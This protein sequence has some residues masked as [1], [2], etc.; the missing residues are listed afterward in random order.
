L[1]R[2]QQGEYP[3]LE[4]SR[5]LEVTLARIQR[6][7][8]D[9]AIAE[10]CVSPFAA[11]PLDKLKEADTLRD[12]FLASLDRLRANAV[13]DPARA[14][15]LRAAF[16]TSY[17]ASRGTTEQMRRSG[18]LKTSDLQAVADRHREMQRLLE[19]HTAESRAAVAGAFALSAR[20]QSASLRTS[21][22]V[23]LL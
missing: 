6:T 13:V 2:L 19:G 23:G 4:V 9:A 1:G 18:E 11:G 17:T 21:L 22:V 7:L 12:S 5:D 3:A 15:A 8:E 14:D 20:S 10:T 16:T